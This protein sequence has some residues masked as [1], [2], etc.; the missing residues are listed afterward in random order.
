MCLDGYE[1]VVPCGLKRYVANNFITELEEARGPTAGAGCHTKTKLVEPKLEMARAAGLFHDGAAVSRVRW[2]DTRDRLQRD[3][4]DR[5]LQGGIGPRQGESRCG[6][7]SRFT[8]QGGISHLGKHKR[9][10]SVW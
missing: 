7:S 10:R 2:I 6:S 8:Y 4:I 1:A 9:E 3:E 5:R